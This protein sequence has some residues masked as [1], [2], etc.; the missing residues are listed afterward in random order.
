M[1]KLKSYLRA[2]VTQP[3]KSVL[4]FLLW[5][6]FIFLLSILVRLPHF[7]SKN[8]WFDGDEAIIGIM[9]QDL[10]AGN[11]FPF[12]FSGQNYGLSTFEVFSTGIFELILGP[13]IW[14]LRLGGLL[15]FS[16]GVTFVLRTI[17]SD[18]LPRWLFAAI[19]LLLVTFPTWYLW[20][21]MVRGGY[22]TAFLFVCIIFYCLFRMKPST[23]QLVLIGICSGIAFESHVLILLPFSTLIAW[24]LLQQERILVKSVA[25]LTGFILT[26]TLFRWFGYLDAAN[27]G[28]TQPTWGWNSQIENLQLQMHGLVAGF[29]SFS[30]FEM[31]I[32]RPFWWDI[33]LKLF[34]IVSG[35][36]LI[37]HFFYSKS[38]ERKQYLLIFLSISA[39]LILI[40]TIG[41]AS[42]RYW[43]GL[44]TGLL[45]WLI[46]AI[47]KDRTATISILTVSVLCM[48]S[49]AGIFSGSKMK[50]HWYDAG[51][52]EIQAFEGFHK[53]VRET[54]AK[55]I[56]IT[57][58]FVQYQWNYL[59]GK[60]IP[61]SMF[62]TKGERIER[63]CRRVNEIYKENPDD[64][65]I[66]GLW[67]VF[68]TMD[69]IQGFNDDRLQV[70]TKYFI[71]PNA[72][73]EFVQQGLRFVE[74][75]G[76]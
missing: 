7:L 23:V 35:I 24:W 37:W 65:I 19:L 32:P 18:Q 38:V 63:F 36:Y 61:A 9:A 30:H 12:Y 21:S 16:L 47:C 70:E 73:D 57:D 76:G 52:N 10:L 67:G 42:P 60:E 56:F 74:E 11:S 51:V 14:A 54:G 59:Y 5:W 46:V 25:I 72:R 15:L 29:S 50:Q 45:F 2:T 6:G 1:K 31:N 28:G 4:K 26:I 68:F 71:N 41:T 34:L 43:I 8:F 20:G 49:F 66:G 62:R 75:K 58:N 40:S 13:G 33:L 27:W 48:I 17:Q 3:E 64:A 44:F 69:T 53:T 22:V 55:A 39:Y